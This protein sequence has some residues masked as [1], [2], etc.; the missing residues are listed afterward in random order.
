[1][2]SESTVRNRREKPSGHANHPDTAINEKPP[3]LWH[4]IITALMQGS[5][6]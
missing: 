6:S 4:K 5:M 3:L 2:P 1:M